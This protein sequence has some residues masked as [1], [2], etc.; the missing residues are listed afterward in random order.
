MKTSLFCC[1]L[2]TAAIIGVLLA[3]C[4]I[5]RA[6][7]IANEG[8]TYEMKVDPIFETL[9]AQI[10][11]V[12][13]NGKYVTNASQGFGYTMLSGANPAS[14]I[15]AISNLGNSGQ[16]L[17][18]ATNGDYLECQFSYSG[19]TAMGRCRSKNGRDFVLTTN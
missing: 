12:T 15:T 8:R 5:T 3:G 19:S 13:Y 6:T 18:T 2:I 4:G 9:T 7:L 11:G 14:G 16:A 10:D 1:K 17:L